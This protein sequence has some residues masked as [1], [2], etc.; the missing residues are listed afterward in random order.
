MPNAEAL[1]VRLPG[2]SNR[3]TAADECEAPPLDARASQPSAFLISP[4][5]P[6]TF[7]EVVLGVMMPLYGY[8]PHDALLVAGSEKM[9][10]RWPKVSAWCKS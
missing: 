5:W 1:R 10:A 9:R 3:S 8:A 6:L 2:T 4:T 7:G